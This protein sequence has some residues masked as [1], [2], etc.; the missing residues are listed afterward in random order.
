M[1]ALPVQQ[2]AADL[3]VQAAEVQAWTTPAR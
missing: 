3:L 1:K 2:V